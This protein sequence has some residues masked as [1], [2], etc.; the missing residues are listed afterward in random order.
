[1][2]WFRNPRVKK[3]SHTKRW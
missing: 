1:M 2:E 3:H